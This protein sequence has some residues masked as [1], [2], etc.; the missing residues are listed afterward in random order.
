MT[1]I[2]R[3]FLC[4]FFFGFSANPSIAQLAE[5]DFHTPSYQVI[6]EVDQGN[7]EEARGLLEAWDTSRFAQEPALVAEY[8]FIQGYYQLLSTG[9]KES[10]ASF[11]QAG[12]IY[13]VLGQ[14][15]HR[16]LCEVYLVINMYVKS[17]WEE[18]KQ[19]GTA[20]LE[21]IPEDQL[22]ARAL[23]H[24]I[25]GAS[26]SGHDMA[27]EKAKFHN[28][29]A[30]TYFLS[31]NNYRRLTSIYGIMAAC[32]NQLKNYQG[33]VGFID[34]AQYFAEK[35]GNEQQIAFLNVRKFR[36]LANQKKYTEGFQFLKE[37]EDYFISHPSEQGQL[38]WIN[39]NYAN[40]YAELGD[41][42]KAYTHL[43]KNRIIAADGRSQ[44]NDKRINELMIQYETEKKEQQIKIQSLIIE[45]QSQRSQ[46]LIFG[47]I[48]GL[49]FLLLLSTMG[50]FYYRNQQQEKLAQ[51][52][53][54]YQEQL[55]AAT[56]NTQE[57]ERKRISRDLHD[58]IGQQLSGLKLSFQQ[59]TEKISTQVPEQKEQLGKLE[60]II[61]DASTDVRNLSHQMMP[62]ALQ[63]LGLAPAISDMLE[64]TFPNTGIIHE[65][66]H[67]NINQR[68]P[69]PIE[70]GLYRIAQELVSNILKHAQAKEVSIELLKN[71]QQI[72]MMVEDDGKGF[73]PAQIQKDGHG[74]TNIRS[75]L[76]AIKGEVHFESPKEGGTLVT[77]RVPYQD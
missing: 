59:M 60:K 6:Q 44:E 17:R 69:E 32:E 63:D 23:L 76:Q 50:Y 68:L 8:F 61:Q 47:A 37:A 30:L 3:Y 25:L 66:H 16:Y 45:N 55:L 62:K 53:L 42:E 56:V 58:G 12:K 19:R 67:D 5:Y 26:Y 20:L 54:H 41:F 51:A 33:A 34:S 31:Q 71:R 4:L 38:G 11:T 36:A 9:Q 64:N 70:I 21:E 13:D 7:F 1:L 57:A 29:K 24:N 43:E 39:T 10:F 18:T 2:Q 73:Q 27:Y 46:Q 49:G 75:R 72:V 74:L 35:I 14:E 22:E 65:F 48:G 77:V 52:Q 40:A 28:Q 15:A